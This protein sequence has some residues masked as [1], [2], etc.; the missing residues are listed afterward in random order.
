[1]PKHANRFDKIE[2]I[3]NFLKTYKPPKLNQD[4]IDN[5]NRPINKSEMYD[6]KEKLPTNRSP[7]PDSSMVNFTQHTKR[8]LY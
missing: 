2:E 7:E 3:D 1:M 5:L 6:L 8:N 4:E